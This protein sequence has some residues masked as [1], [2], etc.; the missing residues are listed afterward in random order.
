MYATLISQLQFSLGNLDGI[1]AK[2]AD[3]A[4]SRGFA[5]E[6][7]LTA[8][9]A[10]DMF[11][12]TRQVQITCDAC[13]IAA[14]RVADVAP[15]AFAD[16]ETTVAELRQRI[17][18]TMQFVDSLDLTTTAAQDGSRR[19]PAGYPPDKTMSLHDYIVK[20]QVANFYF[21]MA[22]AYGLLR[23]WGV[24]VGKGDYLGALPME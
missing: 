1:L 24:P 16:T 3:N 8:R 12:L 17:A 11:A 20:R 23:H 14:A 22:T 7:F 21:H 2:A 5:P 10:P 6:A 18:K 13:K 9:L 4:A 19:V 15:P